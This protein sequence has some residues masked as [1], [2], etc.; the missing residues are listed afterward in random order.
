VIGEPA[1]DV[2]LRSNPGSETLNGLHPVAAL[3]GLMD[4]TATVTAA[5]A[6]DLEGA[7]DPMRQGQIAENRAG[8]V[9]GSGFWGYTERVALEA[10]SLSG[11]VRYLNDPWASVD[12]TG[13]VNQGNS[14]W[15]VTMRGTGETSLEG[16]FSRAPGT[17]RLTSLGSDVL[18]RDRFGGTS[19]LIL[20]PAASGTLDVVASGDV[21]IPLT[22]LRLDDV[23]PVYRRGP[24]APFATQAPGT[25]ALVGNWVPGQDP[26]TNGLRDFD[27]IHAGDPE[28]LR[29][30]A[31]A[32]SV[33][34]T[35]S[36]SCQPV[37]PGPQTAFFIPKPVEIVAGRDVVAGNY[38]A[39][40]NAPGDLSSISADRDVRDVAF[41]VSGP[42]ASLVQAGRDVVL[43]L[44]GKP[45]PT[46]ALGG[47][48]VSSGDIRG[49]NP[50]LPSGTAA[51]LQIMAGTAGGVDLDGFGAIYLDPANAAKLARTYLRPRDGD[52]ASVPSLSG[53]MKDLGYGPLGDAELLAAF[54]ALPRAHQETFLLRVYFNELK[55]TGIGYNDPAS[56]GFHRYARGYEAVDRLFPAGSGGRGDVILDGK[57]VETWAQGSVTVVAPH[58]RIAVGSELVDTSGGGGVVTRRG[59]DIRM[60]ADGNIDLYTSRVFTL[61]GGDVTMWTS[62]GSIT[63]GTGAK[64]TVVDVPLGYTMSNDAVVAVNVFGLQ[65]GAGIGVLDALQGEGAEARRSRLDLMAPRGEIDAGDA[66]IRSVGDLNIIAPVVR[67]AENIQVGGK[68]SGVPT[69][70]V[71]NFASLTTASQLSQSAVR[72]GVGPS[73]QAAQQSLA[74]LPSIITV[75]VIGYETTEPQPP[76]KEKED[77]ERRRVKER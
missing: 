22:G 24:L 76:S 61:Q 46:A 27:P 69:V 48:A 43:R 66:G 16:M 8:G 44:P 1:R 73:P 25:A 41:Q 34:A 58:G 45:D 72:E 37:A 21:I 47:L 56:P 30:V 12:L 13:P 18:L 49:R 15:V 59:G 35:R 10:T 51:D 33:C 62:N 75:E 2:P 40:N 19:T 70:E 6:V 32:G 65:T 53:Y 28:P 4:A 54:H 3:F 9:T 50:A 67:G 20:A 17:L 36:G 31:G 5:G 63:A 38:Q 11:P 7:F 71:P 68:A 52:P 39:Q 26:A 14:A 55:E 60:M 64:T 57:Q 23:A 74:Q 29:I 42:G 77:E